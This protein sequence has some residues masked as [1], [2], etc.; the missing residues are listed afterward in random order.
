MQWKKSLWKRH[1]KSY[2]APCDTWIPLESAD[3]NKAIHWACAFGEAICSHQVI[4]SSRPIVGICWLNLAKSE[5][6]SKWKM[7]LKKRMFDDF[8]MNNGCVG[9]CFITSLPTL[10][11]LHVWSQVFLLDTLMTHDFLKACPFWVAGK[12]RRVSTRSFLCTWSVASPLVSLLK[13]LVSNV[14]HLKN[15]GS[16]FFSM[17]PRTPPWKIP[18]VAQM[19]AG[20]PQRHLEASDDGSQHLRANGNLRASPTPPTVDLTPRVDL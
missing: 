18:Q 6:L 19:L 11:I 20:L 16:S 12:G 8:M 14:L 10:T 2:T 3:P 15:L 17:S 4:E 13:W 1:L 7:I 9:W 5:V